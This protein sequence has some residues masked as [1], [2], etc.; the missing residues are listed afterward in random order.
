MQTS[1]NSQLFFRTFT[2]LSGDVERPDFADGLVDAVARCA[3]N[4]LDSAWVDDAPS[5]IDNNGTHPSGYSFM[6]SQSS[7]G[8]DGF[9]GGNRPRAG[10]RGSSRLSTSLSKFSPSF[11]R[12]GSYSH[13]ASM[14]PS[15]Y[16]SYEDDDDGFGGTWAADA[17]KPK[18]KARDWRESGVNFGAGMSSDED[19]SNSRFQPSAPKGRSRSGTITPR[20]PHLKDQGNPF[21]N[22]TEL[23]PP[24]RDPEDNVFGDN[25][26][27]EIHSDS[28]DLYDPRRGS[29]DSGRHTINSNN[30]SDDAF[31]SPREGKFMFGGQKI[32]Q[33][34]AA[35]DFDDFKPSPPPR[36]RSQSHVGTAL[37]LYEFT[38][39]EDGD[40]SF[41]KG[42]RID[43]LRKPPGEEW[44]VGR[45]GLRQ[46]ILPKN[47]VL[48]DD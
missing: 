38:G 46:G 43:I 36:A 45:I 41:K 12:S 3:G 22:V 7:I 42:D 17:R 11:S 23:D 27:I 15:S 5:P 19:V 34:K 16:R 48:M 14:D 4:Q 24:A 47:Y 10:S 18:P 31:T 1:Q 39:Q 40:L 20:K 33:E 30:N 35:L 2:V 44:W 26:R 37:A 6:S 32:S 29:M 9:S 25:Q 28:D 8:S 13:K 21:E